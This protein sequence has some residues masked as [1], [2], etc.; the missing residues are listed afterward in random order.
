[1]FSRVPDAQEVFELRVGGPYNIL[2][3][4]CYNL[5]LTHQETETQGGK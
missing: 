5:H 1:M 2:R 4:V 3:S